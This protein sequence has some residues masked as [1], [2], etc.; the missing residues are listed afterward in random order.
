MLAHVIPECAGLQVFTLVFIPRGRG[1]SQVLTKADT[2]DPCVV[3]KASELF[4]ATSLVTLASKT[5]RVL[6]SGSTLLT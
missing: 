6:P 3:A 5:L 2:K 4:V 1:D